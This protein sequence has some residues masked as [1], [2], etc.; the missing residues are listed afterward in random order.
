MKPYSFIANNRRPGFRFCPRLPILLGAVWLA[1]RAWGE[2]TEP[3][4]GTP[5]P[6]LVVK[7]TRADLCKELTIP[8]EFHPYM[9][10]ELQAKVAGYVKDMNVD[11]GDRVR[12]GQVLATLEVPELHNELATALAARQRAEADGKETH[13]AYPARRGIAFS[14]RLAANRS[15]DGWRLW[16]KANVFD[17]SLRSL[18]RNRSK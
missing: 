5:P 3:A 9:E 18:Y 13:L 6:A 8:A 4:A 14:S 15:P 1:G 2:G 17:S 16:P 7:V 12:A 11:I 10:V